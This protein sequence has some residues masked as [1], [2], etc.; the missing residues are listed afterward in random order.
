MRATHLKLCDFPATCES[1]YIIFKQIIS[2]NACPAHLTCNHSK[3]PIMLQLS[4][5]KILLLK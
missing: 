4:C 1:K 3:T 5:A 2:Y